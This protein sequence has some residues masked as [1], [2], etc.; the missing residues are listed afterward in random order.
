MASALLAAIRDK[1]IAEME[2]DDA[3][4]ESLEEF[5]KIP[6]AGRLAEYTLGMLVNE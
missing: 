5:Q 1:A 2:D 4:K 6:S 3:K